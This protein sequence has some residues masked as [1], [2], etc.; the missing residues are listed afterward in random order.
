M[1]ER[2]RVDKLTSLLLVLCFLTEPLSASVAS[3]LPIARATP[4][5]ILFN[6]QAIPGHLIGGFLRGLDHVAASWVRQLLDWEL[7]EGLWGYE[8]VRSKTPPTPDSALGHA[9]PGQIN[10][11]YSPRGWFELDGE[12]L[13]DPWEYREDLHRVKRKNA[14]PHR[15]TKPAFEI[16]SPEQSALDGPAD[17]GLPSLARPVDGER[18]YRRAED[19]AA[20]LERVNTRIPHPEAAGGTHF[21]TYL[22]PQLR[23]VEKRIYPGNANHVIP[24]VKLAQDRLGGLC[25]GFLMS[26]ENPPRLFME[27]LPSLKTVLDQLVSHGRIAEATDLL[28]QYFQLNIQIFGRSVVNWDPKIENY[29]VRNGT[30]VV[31]IDP[32]GLKSSK[33]VDESAESDDSDIFYF[34]TKMSE[35]VPSDLRAIFQKL[36][37]EFR[38]SNGGEIFQTIQENVDHEKPRSIIWTYVVPAA[39]PDMPTILAKLKEYLGESHHIWALETMIK[40]ID[41][42]RRLQELGI[43]SSNILA[44]RVLNAGLESVDRSTSLYPL[45]IAE[46]NIFSFLRP[47]GV[48]IT[49]LD[50]QLE[51]DPARG[52]TFGFVQQMPFPDNSFD[53]M[54]SVFLLNLEY[55][56]FITQDLS[57]VPKVF[58]AQVAREIQ[59]VLTDG[60]VFLGHFHNKDFLK[61]CEAIGFEVIPLGKD[62]NRG[63]ALI[64]HKLGGTT[65]PGTAPGTSRHGDAETGKRGVAKDLF[66]IFPPLLGFGLGLHAAQQIMGPLLSTPDGPSD[67][68]RPA[69]TSHAPGLLNRKGQT[70]EEVISQPA[71]VS[72]IRDIDSDLRKLPLLEGEEPFLQKMREDVSPTGLGGQLR[73]AVA[74]KRIQNLGYTLISQQPNDSELLYDFL[75]ALSDDK[76][77]VQLLIKH[78]IGSALWQEKVTKEVGNDTLRKKALESLALLR[79]I[80]RQWSSST[81]PA[82]APDNERRGEGEKGGQGE[83]ASSDLGAGPLLSQPDGH[84]DSSRATAT[85]KERAGDKTNNQTFHYKASQLAQQLLQR[86]HLT[87]S[88][89]ASGESIEI[90]FHETDKQFSL[91]ARRQGRPVGFLDVSMKQTGKIFEAAVYMAQDH[92][93]DFPKIEEGWFVVPEERR[94]RIGESLMKIGLAIA[95]T[96]GVHRFNAYSVFHDKSVSQYKAL[97]FKPLVLADDEDLSITRAE[98]MALS[99]LDDVFLERYAF[100]N[101]RVLPADQ[102]GSPQVLSEIERSAE[103]KQDPEAAPD[104]ERRG[105]GE[106]GGQGETALSDPLWDARRIL[107]KENWPP[108]SIPRFPQ[109]LPILQAILNCYQVTEQLLTTLR[110]D[111][112]TGDTERSR[113]TLKRFE[114]EIPYLSVQIAKLSSPVATNTSESKAVGDIGHASGHVYTTIKLQAHWWARHIGDPDAVAGI[115]QEVEEDLER[116]RAMLVVYGRLVKDY[117]SATAPEKNGFSLI[118]AVLFMTVLLGLTGLHVDFMIWANRILPALIMGAVV[119]NVARSPSLRSLLRAA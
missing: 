46:E 105:E 19:L 79:T 119:S 116:V 76:R 52:H 111:L 9:R 87:L 20:F 13:L 95:W 61:Q 103:E 47:L 89:L 115:M 10:Q 114:E 109:L 57:R 69:A 86:P 48:D 49:A 59:R 74:E 85:G 26:S 2:A 34:Y 17:S 38:L 92:D 39:A 44:G 1:S 97:G 72:F 71:W 25:A 40:G 82:A 15:R 35:G 73:R 65:D 67:S 23:V 27:S 60:G 21:Q 3:F 14:R 51:N 77:G 117:E 11:R 66:A 90:I 104:N 81:Q 96:K 68:P 80:V 110:S 43:H 64:N 6:H 118:E 18:V 62:A 30:E 106:K 8:R 24:S 42:N 45:R 37:S 5:P 7:A 58:H 31:L 16:R 84:S 113:A 70:Y 98:A 94:Q 50:P 107:P 32:G 101:G 63:Y 12:S 93:S 75:D 55:T 83:T 78:Y 100:E 53:R 108:E 88:G 99:K 54:I 33:E 4:T 29:G 36:S 22:Y 56:Q 102:V 112:K 41:Q 91:E 28:R